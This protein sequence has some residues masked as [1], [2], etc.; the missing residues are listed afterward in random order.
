VILVRERSPEEGH[1]SV[2][3][4]LVHGALVAVDGL[5]HSLEHR[6]QELSGIFGVA[7]G[8]VFHR[9]LEVGEEHGDLLALAL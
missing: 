3:H 4:D 9:T 7:I 1:D 2:A 8:Q 5:H 6:V